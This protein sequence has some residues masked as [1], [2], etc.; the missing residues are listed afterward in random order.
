MIKKLKQWLININLK[1]EE[2]VK[3]KRFIISLLGIA[4]LSPAFYLSIIHQQDNAQYI[5]GTGIVGIIGWF[6]HNQT[7]RPS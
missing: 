6:V 5:C 2:K 7:K 3:N 1:I 4:V